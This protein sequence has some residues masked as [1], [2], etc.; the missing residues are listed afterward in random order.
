MIVQSLTYL[1]HALKIVE[2]VKDS[3]LFL[4]IS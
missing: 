1:V 4:V 2:V 3:T